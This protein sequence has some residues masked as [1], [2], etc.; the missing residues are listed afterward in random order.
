MLHKYS[1]FRYHS[2]GYGNMIIVLQNDLEQGKVYTF[3]VSGDLR[4]TENIPL[5]ENLVIQFTSTDEAKEKEGTIMESFETASIFAG[6]LENSVGTASTPTYSKSTTKKIFG[7]AGGLFSYKFSDFRG[8]TAFWK[9]S[10]TEAGVFYDGDIVGVHVNG[11]FNKH[12]LYL[13]FTSGTDVKYFKPGS[14][15]F[16]G[17]KY[18]Q[19][20]LEG[21]LYDTPYLFT[22]IK[23]VQ[24]ESPI[25]MKGSF[26]LDNIICNSAKGGVELVEAD[27]NAY[28]VTVE[29]KT[30]KI[31]GISRISSV[32][33]YDTSG[34]L[35]ATS[36]Q[37]VVN[38]TDL[39][40]GIYF[41]RIAGDGNL[42]A[43]KI[44]L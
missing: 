4:D 44:K 19:V 10:G 24:V 9:Y 2:H 42:Y 31:C 32:E 40:T 23:L 29:N 27:G 33:V 43:S 39:L 21:L 17:W 25:T 28:S 22:G 36:T 12:E 35:V 13:E 3:T 8:G 6:N 38:L 41:L 14:L 18:L 5:T 15:D 7:K 20:K 30:V 37:D 34:K 26:S 16:R 11:D 1:N